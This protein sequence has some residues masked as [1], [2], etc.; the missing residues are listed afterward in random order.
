MSNQNAVFK[1]MLEAGLK[2]ED[3]SKAMSESLSTLLF[4][5]QVNVYY[6]FGKVHTNV[7][8]TIKSGYGSDFK[9]IRTI[10]KEEVFTE[11]QIKANLNALSNKAGKGWK[12]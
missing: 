6:E 8:L 5:D 10:K 7:N 3:A 4:Y 2:W 12:W 11:E 1:E 9:F